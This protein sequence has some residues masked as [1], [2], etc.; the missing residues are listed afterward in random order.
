[1]EEEDDLV[2]AADDSVAVDLAGLETKGLLKKSWVSFYPCVLYES[3]KLWNFDI[4]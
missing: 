3:L 2:A 1:M 4:E